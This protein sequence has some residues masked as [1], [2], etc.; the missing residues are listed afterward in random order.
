MASEKIKLSATYTRTGHV[1]IRDQH[2]REFDAISSDF[3]NTMN[4]TLLGVAIELDH[5]RGY[6][7]VELRIPLEVER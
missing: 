1:E 3:V 6:A 4:A 2:G 7:V 5:G